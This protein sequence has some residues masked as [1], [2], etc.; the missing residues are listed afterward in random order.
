MEGR[1]NLTNYNKLLAR[2]LSAIL[3]LMLGWAARSLDSLFIQ[4]ELDLAGRAEMT[5]AQ[6]RA[7]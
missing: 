7:K 3:Q 4:T 6:I 2:P 1:R 5:A